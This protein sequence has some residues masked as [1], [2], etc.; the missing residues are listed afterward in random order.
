MQKHYLDYL[1]D[2]SFKGVDWLFVLSSENE[3]DR[4]EHTGYF[5]AKGGINS[6]N[7]EIDGRIFY[8]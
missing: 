4:K 8:D 1:I 5:L 3:A 7:V 6:Y 2:W